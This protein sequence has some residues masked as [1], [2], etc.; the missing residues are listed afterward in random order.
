MKLTPKDIDKTLAGFD[1]RHVQ[2]LKALVLTDPQ[3]SQYDSLL[4]RIPGPDDVGATWVLKAW[5]EANQ[6]PRPAFSAVFATLPDLS[7]P[8]AILHVLQMVRFCPDLARAHRTVFQSLA[9]YPRVLV[10]V[11]AFDAYVRT[12]TED[13]TEDRAARIRAGLTHRSKAMQARARQ[14][15][16]EFDVKT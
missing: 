2:P 11:W 16:R 8:D 14:L 1:G 9:G 7:E 6:L 5:S 12:Q 13:E 15:A 3:A 4:A 10:N